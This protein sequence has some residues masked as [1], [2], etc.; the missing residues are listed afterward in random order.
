VLSPTATTSAVWVQTQTRHG[1]LATSPW[2]NGKSQP[3]PA[4][5]IGA[6]ALQWLVLHLANIPLPVPY[7]LGN[8][9]LA[10]IGAVVLAVLVVSVPRRRASRLRPGDAIGYS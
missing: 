2:P 9:A 4:V 8:L 5:N 3:R 10:L 1:H 6:H 7:T